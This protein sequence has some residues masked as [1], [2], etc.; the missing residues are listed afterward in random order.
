[1][2]AS[3]FPQ[4]KFRTN[5]EKKIWKIIFHQCMQFLF[6]ERRGVWYGLNLFTFHLQKCT[7]TRGYFIVYTATY[8]L[9]YLLRGP[10]TRATFLS[11]NS[12]LIY[13][14]HNF[15]WKVAIFKSS[16]IWKLACY[17]FQHHGGKQQRQN[18]QKVIIRIIKLL[19]RSCTIVYNYSI[20][21]K[22]AYKIDN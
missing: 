18:Q 17:F 3:N 21:G 4:C 1:V 10:F 19:I 16:M 13:N 14:M 9:S 12:T 7:R 22:N 2:F 11:C 5:F 6:G 8:C 15:C 20:Q